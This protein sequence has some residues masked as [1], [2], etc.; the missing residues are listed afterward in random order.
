MLIVHDNLFYMTWY[1]LFQGMKLTEWIPF[2]LL[3]WI[4]VIDNITSPVAG[5]KSMSTQ[6]AITPMVV[7]QI[8]CSFL[9]SMSLK[10]IFVQYNYVRSTYCVI[11]VAAEFLWTHILTTQLLTIHDTTTQSISTSN[12]E[13]VQYVRFYDPSRLQLWAWHEGHQAKAHNRAS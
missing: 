3:T 13:P 7:S 5:W 4:Q 10:W 12:P 8:L 6:P 11:I 1:I 9:T 2:I